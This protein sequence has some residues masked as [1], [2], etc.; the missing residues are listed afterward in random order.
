MKFA[1]PFLVFL[2]GLT[3]LMGMFVLASSIYI[4][5][6]FS[7]GWEVVISLDTVW[8][9]IAAGVGL[10]FVAAIGLGAAGNNNHNLL[11]IY[12]VLQLLITAILIGASVLVFAAYNGYISE[13]ATVKD[14]ISIKSASAIALNNGLLSSYTACCSGCHF[15]CNNARTFYNYT[16]PAPCLN[17]TC[18]PVLACDSDSTTVIAELLAGNITGNFTEV[19]GLL[20]ACY[21]P[22]QGNTTT[23]MRNPPYVIEQSICSALGLVDG[24]NGAPLVGPVSNGK[25]CGGGVPA[26]YRTQVNS[27]FSSRFYYLG[28]VLGCICALQIFVGMLTFYV[29]M[30]DPDR[31]AHRKN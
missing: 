21:I 25:S 16:T 4:A 28:I 17:E 6:V 19:L 15:G 9:G 24:P 18:L 12:L 11:W 20:N 30:T 8:L 13:A 23:V 10:V 1:R 31:R 29:L 22:D 27:Y 5:S 14:S 7:Q 26:T 3:F 2:N